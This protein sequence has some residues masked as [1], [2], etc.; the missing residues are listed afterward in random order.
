MLSIYRLGHSSL[1]PLQPVRHN[2]T[3]PQLSKMEYHSFDSHPYKQTPLTSSP[4]DA[5]AKDLTRIQRPCGQVLKGDPP[6]VHMFKWAH[7]S[8][9]ADQLD[10]R[11]VA[12]NRLENQ[13]CRK[14]PHARRIDAEFSMLAIVANWKHSWDDVWRGE[15]GLTAGGCGGLGVGFGLS[16]KVTFQLKMGKSVCGWHSNAIEH[17]CLF[18][19]GAIC[20]TCRTAF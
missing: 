11:A 12:D 19:N 20:T 15:N 1:I 2:L 4:I 6:M 18:V 14:S 3:S 10:S 13:V 16:G 8:Y 5:S 9:P 17:N 7:C